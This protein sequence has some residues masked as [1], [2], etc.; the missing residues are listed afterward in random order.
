MNEGEPTR[1]GSKSQAEAGAFGCKLPIRCDMSLS[2][3]LA[4]EW[5]VR[6]PFELFSMKSFP[7]NT[8]T[9][10]SLHYHLPYKT[11]MLHIII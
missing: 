4:W 2:P 6:A 10:P 11:C 7:T 1:C 3:T 9:L 5:A 8:D